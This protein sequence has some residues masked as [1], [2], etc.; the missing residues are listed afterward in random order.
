MIRVLL[1]DDDAVV[2]EGLTVLL[3]GLDDHDVVGAAGG[4]GAAVRRYVDLRPDVVLMDLSMPVVDGVEVTRQIIEPD[5]EARI[6]A[7]TGFGDDDLVADALAAGAHGYLLKNARGTELHDAIRTVAG[8]GSV[9]SDKALQHLIA[10]REPDHV[11]GN[12]PSG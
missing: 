8:G 4:G 10:R 9:L 2:I 12:F 3:A 11:G 6:L 5:P 7:L 1:V